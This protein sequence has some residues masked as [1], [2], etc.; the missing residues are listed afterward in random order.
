MNL[1]QYLGSVLLRVRS[2]EETKQVRHAVLGMFT[3]AGELV[4]IF[5]RL[6]AYGKPVD[7]ANL[8][9]ECGDF[10]WYLVLW[11]WLRKVPMSDL[12]ACHDRMQALTIEEILS[13]G[14]FDEMRDSLVDSLAGTAGKFVADEANGKSQELVGEQ[15]A[16][17]VFCVILGIL[18]LYELRLEDCLKANDEKLELRTGK[19]FDAERFLNRDLAAERQ[20]LEGHV[21][22]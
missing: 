18:R 15:W 22:D 21:R 2:L 9:E 20:A 12:A 5:K 1:E 17:V 13:E 4:D 8:L 11:C 14:S 19:V 3:E 6:L 7:R 16:K 10:L